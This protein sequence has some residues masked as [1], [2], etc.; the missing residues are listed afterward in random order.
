MGATGGGDTGDD[1][2]RMPRTEQGA[3]HNH[4]LRGIYEEP[5]SA[6]NG[7]PKLDKEADRLSRDKDFVFP[8]DGKNSGQRAT[9]LA[10]GVALGPSPDSSS[11]SP[12]HGE[13]RAEY[14]S[15]ADE[16]NKG[17][18]SKETALAKKHW[19]SLDPK[20][21]ES[22]KSDLKAG[23]ES[24][25]FDSFKQKL[26]NDPEFKKLEKE[27]TDN[28]KSFWNGIS[29][30]DKKAILK[31]GL[32]LDSEP[33]S[34]A[35]RKIQGPAAPGDKLDPNLQDPLKELIKKPDGKPAKKQD[36]DPNFQRPDQELF[37]DTPASTVPGKGD[38]VDPRFYEPKPQIGDGIRGDAPSEPVPG[39]DAV[40][41]GTKTDTPGTGNFQKIEPGDL[42]ERLKKNRTVPVNL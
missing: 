4:L 31:E 21:Q 16:A 3:D 24:E 39:N 5:V 41:K 22:I 33:G 34:A 1:I 18:N 17:V 23:K 12:V 11:T 32:K 25:A 7:D 13:Q 26:Q 29:Q 2:V 6:N 15:K 37:K 10:R 20:V 30:Q 19:D 27:R 35:E 9:D 14:K 42:S 28:D 36:L 40:K 38:K 8:S